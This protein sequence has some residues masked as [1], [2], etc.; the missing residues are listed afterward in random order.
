MEHFKTLKAY[1]KAINIPSPRTRHFDIRKF[2]ENMPTVVPQMMPFR[3]EFY[4][5]AIKKEGSG[6]ARTGIHKTDGEG[7][8]L[9]FNSPYQITSWDILPDWEGYYVMFTQEFVS[10]HKVFQDLLMAFPFLRMDNSIPFK[11]EQEDMDNILRIFTSIYQEHHSDFQDRSQIIQAY[12]FVLLNYVKRYY[13]AGQ[14]DTATQDN[15]NQDLQLVSR[16]QTLIEIHLSKEEGFDPAFNPHSTGYYADLLN[17]HPNYLNTIIKR[18]TGQTALKLLH[19]KLFEY[20]QAYL[21]QT[22]LSIK[23]V[24][25]ALHFR[26][27]AHFT[28]FFKKYARLTPQQFRSEQAK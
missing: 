7:Y 1:C 3:H 22:H 6:H 4:A 26:E 20:S 19:R 18:T 17:L 23:E 15:R 2:E 14:F 5:I 25:Y 8:V 9:F 16:F 27:A 11:V 10:K 21:L 24:A 28:N 13:N 12:T